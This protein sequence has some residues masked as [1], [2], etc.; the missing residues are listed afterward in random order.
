MKYEIWMCK[1]LYYIHK[2]WKG[3]PNPKVMQHLV[4]W[5][6]I[7]LKPSKQQSSNSMDQKLQGTFIDGHAQCLHSRWGV[8]MLQ[9]RG[10]FALWYLYISGKIVIDC[11]IIHFLLLIT[12]PWWKMDI[13]KK[14]EVPPPFF[15]LLYSILYTVPKNQSSK[16][17]KLNFKH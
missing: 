11:I 5:Q 1:V 15:F 3:M 6:V 10:S 7:R 2:G 13:K 17:N 9:F 8:R 12:P 16:S 14:Y 4:K